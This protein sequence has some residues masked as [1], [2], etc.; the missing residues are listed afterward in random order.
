M[1]IDGAHLV[2]EAAGD[3]DDHVL[4]QAL[5]GPEAGVVLALAVPDHK[6]DLAAFRGLDHP[7]DPSASGRGTNVRSAVP[8]VHVDVL[9]GCTHFGSIA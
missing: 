7:A 4:D 1:G 9:D 2:E 8:D 6:L 3:A 5:D